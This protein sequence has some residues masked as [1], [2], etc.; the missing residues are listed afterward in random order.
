MPERAD[1]AM[2]LSDA[3]EFLSELT[4]NNS[5]SW[6]KDNK[7]AYDA[8]LKRPA[9]RLIAEVAR[10]LEARQPLPV[11]GKLFRP[12][13]DVRFSEDKTPYHTHL[14][15]LWSLPD[16]RGW[17]LGI[18]VDYASAGAGMMGFD[19]DPLNRYRDAV[20]GPEGAEL[21]AIIDAAG[22]RLNDTALQRVP[23]PFEAD[24]PR[25]ALLR[26][27]G[28]VAWQDD[29]DAALSREP[30]TATQEALSA[31]DPLVAWLEANVLAR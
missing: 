21:Q 14:H 2:L 31:F 28:L 4:E 16:G 22:W 13:R 19:K 26:R 30:V 11:R 27:K 3:R 15:M 8:R 12:Q 6:F 1:P 7:H 25:E 18:A 9:E 17:F 10:W 29:L 20:A 5:R 24:H 23:P